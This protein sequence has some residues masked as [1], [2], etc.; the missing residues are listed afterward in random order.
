MTKSIIFSI[1]AITMVCS[2]FL[3]LE[4]IKQKEKNQPKREKNE[5]IKNKICRKNDF[6]RI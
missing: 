1:F 6:V 5:N 3:F 4:E 2:I